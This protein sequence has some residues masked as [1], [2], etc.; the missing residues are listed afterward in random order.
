MSSLIKGAVYRYVENYGS[1]K[2]Y[3]KFF[4]HSCMGYWMDFRHPKT[5][6]EKL[7]WLKLYDRKPIYTTMVDKYAVKQ[8]VANIIGEQYIIPTLGV[9]NSFDE[10]DFDTLPNQFVLKCTHDSGGLV[11]CKD[12]AKLDLVAAKTKIENS[13]KTDYYKKGREWPYKNVHRRIVAEKYMVDESGKELKDYKIFC[14][15]GK[16]RYVQVD[17]GRFSDHH[18]NIFDTEWN[19]LDVQLCY[20]SQLNCDIPKPY[21]LKE[22]LSMASRLSDKMPFLRVDFY[23]ISGKIFFGEMTFY[24]GSGAEKFTPYQW[25]EIFGSWIDLHKK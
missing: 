11:I 3:L 10:I 14:F 16:P 5:F 15:N 21:G 1:D 13:L 8:Y 19:L 7:Q 25:D 12:K 23:N 18:R 4:F 17:Y 24:P 6:N 2:L 20:A 9:W 22:M